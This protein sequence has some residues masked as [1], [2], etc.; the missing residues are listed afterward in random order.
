MRAGYGLG[1][2][3]RVGKDRRVRLPRRAGAEPPGDAA[4]R[5][6]KWVPAQSLGSSQ[7]VR[8]LTLD[9]EIEGSNPS[10]PAN[11]PPSASAELVLTLVRS[12]S[13]CRVGCVNRGESGATPW[14]N[15]RQKRVKPA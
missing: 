14:R 13:T 10:S 7:A 8:R 4:M 6:V 11:P 9:Q 2:G 3:E 12:S 15:R 5:R 1:P